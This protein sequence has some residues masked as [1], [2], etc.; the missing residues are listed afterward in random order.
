[1]RVIGIDPGL[2]TTGYA[3][4]EKFKIE[5]RIITSG[6]I[7]TKKEAIDRRLLSIY[8][9]LTTIVDNFE[10]DSLAVESGF[11]SKNVDSLIKMSQVKGVVILTG[12][13]KDLNVFEYSP[14][15]V[16]KAIVGRGNA[17]KEQVRYMVEQIT[18]R[19]IEKSFDVSDAI[20]VAICHLH[21]AG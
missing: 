8:N 13:L 17:S 18:K 12:S 7:T 3:V 10:P 20:A 16:K 11:Y 2:G 4:I 9:E 6:V 15:V 5:F 14:A 1:M 21:R 19:K